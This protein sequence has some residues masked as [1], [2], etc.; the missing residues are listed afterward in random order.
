MVGGGE[1]GWWPGADREWVGARRGWSGMW[2]KWSWTC[3]RSAFFVVEACL[4]RTQICPRQ[5]RHELCCLSNHGLGCV[6]PGGVAS[7]THM[8]SAQHQ[9]HTR[10]HPC[11]SNRPPILSSSSTRPP[12]RPLNPPHCFST[13]TRSTPPPTRAPPPLQHTGHPAQPAH[14][15]KWFVSLWIGGTSCKGL[16]CLLHRC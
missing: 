7:V 8:E 3:V 2:V 9:A 14:R 4:Q 6:M 1:A 16:S 10:C 11:L 5:F 15:L 13:P 12:P